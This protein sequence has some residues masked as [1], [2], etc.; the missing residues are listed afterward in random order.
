MIVKIVGFGKKSVDINFSLDEVLDIPRKTALGRVL[1]VISEMVNDLVVSQVSFVS[2][3]GLQGPLEVE[4]RALA[5]LVLDPTPFL[6]L[7]LH[8]TII[9]FDDKHLGVWIIALLQ[10]F[11]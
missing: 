11:T 9:A 7:L 3:R 10:S 5:V 6:Q 8:K 1:V 2:I 4:T